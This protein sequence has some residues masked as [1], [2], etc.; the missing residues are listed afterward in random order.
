MAGPEL[1]ISQSWTVCRAELPESGYNHGAAID[2]DGKAL[3][4]WKPTGI[5]PPH[6]GNPRPIIRT[7]VQRGN[8]KCDVNQLPSPSRIDKP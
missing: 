8:G 3:C 2:A 7:G 6:G 1:I 5:I 4:K